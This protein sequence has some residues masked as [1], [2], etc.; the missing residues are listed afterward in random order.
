MESDKGRPPEGGLLSYRREFPVTRE[1]VYLDHAGVAPVSLRAASAVEGFLRGATGHAAFLY[2]AWTEE[3]ERCRALCARL[4]GAPATDVAFVRNTS[5]GLSLVARGLSWQPGDSV[6]YTE[7][8]FPANVYPWLALAG[9]GVEPRAIPASGAGFGPEDIEPLIDGSTRL[10]AISSLL[11]WSGFRPDIAAIAELCRARGVYLFVDAIQTLGVVPMDVEALGVDFLAADGHKWL[12]APEGAGIF[13]C[14]PE[15]ARLLDPPLVGWKSV[16]NE[17]DYD[18]ID[19]SLK[20]NA[21]R[22]EEGSM[23]MMGIFALGASVEMLL[24]A[25]IEAVSERVLALTGMV[26]EEARGRG[27]VVRTPAEDSRRAGIV[28]FTG[29]FDAIEVRGELKR[30]GVMVNVRR[31]GLRVAPHFYNTEAE[32]EKFF[33]ELDDILGGG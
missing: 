5:H 9:R 23:N 24:E 22:F 14:R 19:L 15:L 33:S 1:H 8:D 6:V 3:I 29:G 32:I 17:W 2:D 18:N 25:G 7:G 20:P 27:F 16:E 26:I 4:I 31:G 10:V 12:L 13:Y 21:L 11:Y 30:R 28:S